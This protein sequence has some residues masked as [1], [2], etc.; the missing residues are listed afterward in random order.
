MLVDHERFQR[1]RRDLQDARGLLHQLP[2][3]RLRDVSV[4]A[5]NSNSRLL[6]Q[7]V[8]TPELV[9]D[10]CFKRCDIEHADTLRRFF[11]QQGQNRKEGRFRLAGRSRR[12]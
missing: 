9:V 4:P 10:Q 6:A 11:I 2:L 5:I 7:L 3:L 12:R 1:F 8:Q